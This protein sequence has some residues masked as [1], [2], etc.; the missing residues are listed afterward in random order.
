MAYLYTAMRSTKIFLNLFYGLRVCLFKTCAIPTQMLFI[1]FEGSVRMTDR[2][3]EEALRKQKCPRESCVAWTLEAQLFQLESNSTIYWL[4]QL[5][6]VSS[7][8]ESAPTASN[9]HTHGANSWCSWWFQKKRIKGS[10]QDKTSEQ[11]LAHG[12]Q[13]TLASSEACLPTWEQRMPWDSTSLTIPFRGA[14]CVTL[15]HKTQ[16]TSWFLAFIN[17][18][19]FMRKWNLF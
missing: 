18:R 6:V 16:H 15:D 11:C 17:F 3:C 12:K 1:T 10:D 5:G 8:W 19:E 2:S 9:G 13:Q 7:L 4:C 14:Q